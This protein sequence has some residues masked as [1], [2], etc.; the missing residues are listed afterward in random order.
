LSLNEAVRRKERA[1]DDL[2]RLNLENTLRIATGKA[3]AETLD[4]LKELQ[5]AELDSKIAPELQPEGDS[6]ELTSAF[7][8]GAEA[9]D[10]QQKLSRN[11]TKEK[12]TTTDSENDLIDEIGEDPMLREAGRVLADLVDEQQSNSSAP[13]V[14]AASS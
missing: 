1:Q 6:K 12:A 4:S 2:W 10:A 3:T 8:E 5:K 7:I 13:K 9:D 14:V 11:N